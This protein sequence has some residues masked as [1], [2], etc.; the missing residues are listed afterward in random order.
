[1]VRLDQVSRSYPILVA[2]SRLSAMTVTETRQQNLSKPKKLIV[3]G[4]ERTTDR[5]G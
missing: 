3:K 2:L 1:M 4:G 5:F